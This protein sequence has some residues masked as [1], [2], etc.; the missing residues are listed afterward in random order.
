[1]MSISK[2]CALPTINNVKARKCVGAAC[3]HGVR[4]YACGVRACMCAVHA[5]VVVR[6]CD[7]E[8]HLYKQIA[9][10]SQ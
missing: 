2:G 10:F 6:V 4:M 3:V 5:R 8:M 7:R 9:S 1:M